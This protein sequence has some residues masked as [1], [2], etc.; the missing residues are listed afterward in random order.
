MKSALVSRVDDR[1][2]LVVKYMRSEHTFKKGKVGDETVKE[3]LRVY[4]MLCLI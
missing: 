3:L 1:R 4:D 2:V